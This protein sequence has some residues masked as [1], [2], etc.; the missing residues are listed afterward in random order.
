MAMGSDVCSMHTNTHGERRRRVCAHAS[1]WE[2]DAA[3]DENNSYT[4]YKCCTL[5]SPEDTSEKRNELQIQTNTCTQYAPYEDSCPTFFGFRQRHRFMTPEMVTE[6]RR[7]R[8]GSDCQ[9][10]NNCDNLL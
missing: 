10:P 9:G 3:H 5:D 4:N 8:G 7:K 6:T 2:R 1:V